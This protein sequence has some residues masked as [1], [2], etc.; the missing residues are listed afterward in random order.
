MKSDDLV[1]AG[2]LDEAVEWL[3]GHLRDNPTDVRA[4]TS[5]LSINPLCHITVH[6]DAVSRLKV[7]NPGSISWGGV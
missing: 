2:K 1:R 5:L 6:F 3:S 7:R 4:R